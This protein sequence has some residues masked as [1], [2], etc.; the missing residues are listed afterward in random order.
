TA[1]RWRWKQPARTR[2][3][4]RW[5]IEHAAGRL[6]TT[7]QAIR[8]VGHGAP[9]R[10]HHTLRRNKEACM[11]NA[12]ETFR[13]PIE[14]A[15]ASG[16][17]FVPA[18]FAAWPPQ[19]VAIAGIKRGHAVLDVACGTGIVARTAADRLGAGSH[20]VGLDLN[21]AMLAVARRVRPELEWR[22]GDVAA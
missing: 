20:V 21:E 19:L 1:D 8:T 6:G 17:K 5:T 18:V 12:T 2:E 3:Q 11:Q 10:P 16:A 15:G 7:R 9:P 22:Q 4:A 13:I 14:V